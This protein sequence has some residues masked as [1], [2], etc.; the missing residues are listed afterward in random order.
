MKKYFNELNQE[1]IRKVLE[2]NETLFDELSQQ[3]YEDK[4]YCQEKEG[5]SIF[6]NNWYK[7][8]DYNDNYSSFYLRLKDWEEFIDNLDKDYIPQEGI[9]L[10]NYIQN[11]K[12]V[13]NNMELGTDNYYNL[14]EHLE[15]KSQELL[16]ICE[17]M[18]HSYENYPNFEEVYDYTLDNFYLYE[19][20]Y[21]NV[22]KKG[23][24][25]YI[26]YQDIKYTKSFE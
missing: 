24:T 19:N 2:K 12:A 13:L 8:I 3:L 10:Y 7:Y 11:K 5:N 23:N 4:M 16:D 20:C 26:L 17:N 9:D 15:K 22:D 25:D 6:G 1:E 14:E 18:L 21:I